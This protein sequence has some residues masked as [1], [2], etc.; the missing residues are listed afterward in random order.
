[1]AP[2]SKKF[3]DKFF[4]HPSIINKLEKKTTPLNKSNSFLIM[5]V[6]IICDCLF[7]L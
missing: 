7:L 2:S 6:L 1:M 5:N 4:L 3:F